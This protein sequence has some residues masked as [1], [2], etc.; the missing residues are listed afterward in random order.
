MFS[1]EALLAI[2][3]FAVLIGGA[4]A[5]WW[6]DRRA[7][8]VPT[9]D[10][11]EQAFRA[12]PVAVLVLRSVR[13]SAGGLVDF[14]CTWMNPAAE[15][16][17][18]IRAVDLVGK[19]LRRA[20]PV[21]NAPE[22]FA[23][24]MAFLEH[25]LEPSAE[26]RS[27]HQGRERWWLRSIARSGDGVVLVLRDITA[28]RV[29]ERYD[30]L[31]AT[32][33]ALTMA[34]R[35]AAHD[36]GRPLTNISRAEDRL[37]E[38][39]ASTPNAIP[40]LDDLRSTID[41]TREVMD[42]MVASHTMPPSER[43]SQDAHDMLRTILDSL[44]DRMKADGLNVNSSYLAARTRMEVA[45][46]PL[47]TALRFLLSAFMDLLPRGSQL[48]IRTSDVGTR[49]LL[50]WSASIDEIHADRLDRFLREAYRTLPV[51][52]NHFFG[53]THAIFLAHN[54]ALECFSGKGAISVRIALPVD[55]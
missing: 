9:E 54:A 42:R 11:V 28:M 31:K 47:Y 35:V 37:R 18:G 1:H 13:T 30:H 15:A 45:L 2:L 12:M 17:F 39:M 23:E 50:E 19:P 41:D 36:L 53:H 44:S 8:T 52:E 7:D 46:T 10:P 55:Q 51:D 33:D 34:A 24:Y 4:G 26:L 21:F 22:H 38:E 40:Y 32:L 25:G 29:R 49:M 3:G 27:D 6:L 43:T 5:F 20:V 14:N 16:Y 48:N